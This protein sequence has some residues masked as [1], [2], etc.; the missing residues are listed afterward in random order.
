MIWLISFFSHYCDKI[1]YKS[2]LKEKEFVLAC[3]SSVPEKTWQQARMVQ[4][5]AAA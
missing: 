2:N 3:V 4:K 5:Q 1:S